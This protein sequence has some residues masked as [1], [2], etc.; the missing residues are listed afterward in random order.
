MR[1]V[2]AVPAENKSCGTSTLCCKLFDIEGLDRPKKAGSWCPHCA[3]GKGCG[4]WEARP[5]MCAD[6]YCVWRL[7][8]TLGP[9]WKPEVSKFILTHAHRDAPLAVIVDPGTPNAHRREPYRTKLA[10]TSRDI[11]NGRG[12][13]V[14][15][16]VG[17]R[18]FVILPDREEEIPVGIEL[19]EVKVHRYDRP[20]GAHWEIS[21]P[22]RLAG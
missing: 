22:T 13:P 19:H 6:Y 1:W 14:V 20:G 4:I 8:A 15:A 10:A 2:D 3:P 11:L 5:S 12:Q 21:F 16:F 9:E 7:D 17:S 18:R